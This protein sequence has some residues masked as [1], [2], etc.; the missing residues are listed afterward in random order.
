MSPGKWVMIA[1]AAAIFSAVG[2]HTTEGDW[3]TT[4]KDGTSQAYT[5]FLTRHPKGPHS[6]EAQKKIAELD[7]QAAKKENTRASYRSFLAK[8]PGYAD[9]E[10][11]YLLDR[12]NWSIV[13]TPDG[14]SITSSDPADLSGVFMMTK[15]GFELP[16]RLTGD[17]TTLYYTGKMV[18]AG[19][20]FEGNLGPG[21]RNFKPT[22]LETLD[23]SN[24]L[25][26]AGFGLNT[27]GSLRIRV[28]SGLSYKVTLH[29]IWRVGQC[30]EGLN[31]YPGDLDEG[32][33]SELP[34]PCSG[35]HRCPGPIR[36]GSWGPVGES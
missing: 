33:G 1:L 24:A 15:P 4:Q 2:C 7:W 8:H 29:S 20:M 9:D 14:I 17:A 30:K 19:P 25:K 34:C 35:L 32:P 11:Q 3:K 27:D 12:M 23:S 31:P 5:D 22:R 21:T 28:E 36:G 6:D 10:V 13:S 26:I 18:L 16:V